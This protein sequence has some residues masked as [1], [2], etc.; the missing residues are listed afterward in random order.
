[1]TEEEYKEIFDGWQWGRG[2]KA[3]V[4]GLHF[5]EIQR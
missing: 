1:M 4:S 5:G 2:P 3:H